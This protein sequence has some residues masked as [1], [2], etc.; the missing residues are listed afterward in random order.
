MAT[1]A[2]ITTPARQP[3]GILNESKL[4]SL[5]SVK[6]R[7]NAITPNSAPTSLKRRA[8]SPEVE[9]GS[10]SENVD[11][12][13]LD[14]LHKRKRSALDEDV[15]LAKT[16]RIS[17][18]VT[19]LPPTKPRLSTTV[20]STP[21][22]DTFVKPSTTPASAPAAGRSPTRQRSGLLQS[23]KR[24]NPPP[25]A[26]ATQSPSLSLSAALKGTKKS[27]VHSRRAHKST[28]IETSKP[29]SWFFDIYEE[30]EEAQDYRMNEWTMTQSATGLDISDD[31]SKSL[32]KKSSSADRGKE[33][34]D[35]NEVTAPVTRSMAAAATQKA[36]EKE[37]RMNDNDEAARSPLADL[38]PAEFY[39]EGLDATS[40]VLVQDDDEEAETDVEGDETKPGHDFAFQPST[41][42][43]TTSSASLSSTAKIIENLNAPS[44]AEILSSATP[45]PLLAGETL[46]GKARAPGY[47]L[48]DA[49]GDVEIEIWESESA[50]D[51]N[52]KADLQQLEN[53]VVVDPG[54]PCSSV[55]DQNV[56]ALQEL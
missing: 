9:G 46:L 7:Q 5:Q 37:V 39:A 27:R 25:F 32:H 52:E 12:N 21:R 30:T 3:F 36:K 4:R 47:P 11:P 15:S 16:H 51:E 34:I 8:P 26:S 1:L 18:N 17:F 24:F 53:A 49:D 43:T 13:V 40:V 41:T 20:V 29:K 56:F 35:P 6:N 45:N 33:N 44:L 23:R 14:S 28:T 48:A 54:S 50:K 55:G 22:L 42:T 2:P 10:D 38:N 19:T 31:E